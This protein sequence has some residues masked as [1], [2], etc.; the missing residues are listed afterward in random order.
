[1][2]ALLVLLFL[3]PPGSS[4]T[5]AL[6]EMR[7]TL[8]PAGTGAR[9]QPPS[10]AQGALP[11]AP[12]TA[13]ELPARGADPLLSLNLG[14]NF[15]I[16]VKSQG[17]F[18]PAGPSTEPALADLP[19]AEMADPISSANFLTPGEALSG[20]SSAP[21]SGWLVTG[22]AD[23]PSP[24]ASHSPGSWGETAADWDGSPVPRFRSSPRG[25]P[26]STTPFESEFLEPVPTARLSS[27]R[28]DVMLPAA[29]QPTPA[30]SPRGRSQG[31]EF[32]INIDLTAGLDQE[33]GAPPTHVL[34]A[35]GGK[36]PG[37]RWKV[38]LLP[39]LK[40]GIS[41]I[42]SKLG[43]SSFFGPT[44]PPD[45]HQERNS[46]G[47]V[48]EQPQDTSPSPPRAT[49][50]GPAPGRHGPS[51]GSEGALA[52]WPRCTPEKPEECGS[53]SPEPEAPPGP[54][55]LPSPPLFVTLHADWNTAMA[56]WGL[57]WEAHVYGAGSLFSLLALLSLLGL[58]CL[59][60]RC[61]AGCTFLAALELLLLVAGA[62]RAFLLFYDAYGQQERLPAFASLLLHDLPFPCLSSA[63]A[64]AFLLL[65]T[66]SRVKLSRARFR[67]PGCL[68]ALVLLHFFVAVGAVLAADLLRQSP[69]LLLVSRGAYALLAA[70]LSLAFLAFY[71]QGRADAGQSYDLHSSTPPTE[72][73]SRCPFADAGDWSR[74]ARTTL[75]AACFALLSAALQA[76]A[77]LHALGYGLPPAFFGPWPWWSLQLGCRLCEVGTGLPLALV[78]LYPLV[79]SHEPPC[80][81]CWGALFRG[82]VK[83]PV[84]PNNFQWAVAQHEKLVTCDTITRSDSE[85]LPLYALAGSR[86]SAD[87]ATGDCG[88]HSPGA[89]RASETRLKGG[90]GSMT[91]SI[92]SMA[93]DG[94]P[95]A[96]FR[97]P[98]PINLRRSIDEALF[99]EAL[100]PASLFQP[101][102]A[103]A[104]SSTL[105]LSLLSPG[106]QEREGRG[107]A[108]ASRGL[109]RT[110]SC[111]ELETALPQG[112]DGEASPETSAPDTPLCSPGRWRGSSRCSSSPYGHSLDG[113][114]LVLCPSPE[115][116]TH[117]SSFAYEPKLP[118][119]QGES[120][121]RRSPPPPGGP[122]LPLAQ[123]SQES[124]DSLVPEPPAGDA[125]LLQEEFMDVCRQID[126]LSVSSDTIDL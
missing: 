85:F 108:P 46:T 74:A 116:T 99:S 70:L 30:S 89:A 83:A 62:A 92:I 100:I 82:P 38:P 123:P 55:L 115:Q 28:P 6:A 44:L 19:P 103:L 63:L 27:F 121:P 61:P 67:H 64:V 5:G 111:M 68:A 26:P 51:P 10:A 79:C 11:K 97:P 73:L 37:T 69:F 90:Y 88:A 65:S 32:H 71:C 109:Y 94:D 114:S 102:G 50:P 53:P 59:P 60:V 41:E 39:S 4:A 91:S 42:A 95:T 35:R 54:R 31:L 14:L 118:R 93:M 25:H 98:S 122:Y 110:S 112:G 8:P 9:A 113:S 2:W 76:Y 86:L 33:V 106:L 72:R 77:V 48:W 47:G 49:E 23:E 104:R 105:A 117:A 15:K 13:S 3:L 80:V 124:L 66:R 81:R 34:P 58:A 126:A 18:R 40:A 21:G 24:D 84:L 87:G 57:A 43:T 78:G 12:L 22:S 125:A 36:G 56:D 75:L 1:M 29:R 96:D 17:S 7:Q 119:G 20:S 16:K 101:A 120:S 107:E 45:W 52:A